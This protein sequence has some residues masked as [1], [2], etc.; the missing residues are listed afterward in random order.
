MR[1]ALDRRQ[2]EALRNTSNIDTFKFYL[3]MNDFLLNLA[4]KGGKKSEMQ[5]LAQVLY[6]A[7]KQQEKQR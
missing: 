6:G 1:E 3:N 7:K 4:T 5:K 2:V